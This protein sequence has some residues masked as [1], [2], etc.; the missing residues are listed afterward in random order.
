MIIL[1]SPNNIN[2]SY[3]AQIPVPNPEKLPITIQ[4]EE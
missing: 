3:M 1:Q 4:L 2:K